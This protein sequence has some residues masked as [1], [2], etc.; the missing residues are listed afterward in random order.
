MLW[1]PFS[2]NAPGNLMHHQVFE[3]Y[4]IFNENKSGEF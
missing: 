1:D 3:M 4:D 2:S